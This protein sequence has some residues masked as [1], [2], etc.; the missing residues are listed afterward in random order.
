MK[1]TRY[2]SLINSILNIGFVHTIKSVISLLF[3]K[4]GIKDKIATLNSE[5]FLRKG[6]SDIACYRQ[7]F[8][9]G[10]YEIP[11]PFEPKI[12]LDLGANIGLFA[13]RMQEKFQHC[14]I[15]AVEPEIGN[16]KQL[17]KN[18]HKLKNIKTYNKA[19]WSHSGELFIEMSTNLGE[20][21]ASTT[22]SPSNQKIEAITINNLFELESIELIDVVKIDIEGAE[23]KVFENAEEW[24]SK[25]RIIIIELHDWKTPGSSN[26]FIR[27]ISKL[28]NFSIS[29]SG[30][31]IIVIN[32]SLI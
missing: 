14:R 18:T 1:N 28:E 24:I 8:M 23:E 11:I 20:W 2:H 25:T 22:T 10:E 16:F 30:E 17:Q 27:S 19:I 9:D 3:I 26:P 12:I 4:Y 21:G 32:N 6:T 15:I 5:A 29:Q 31:N 13:L 7:I